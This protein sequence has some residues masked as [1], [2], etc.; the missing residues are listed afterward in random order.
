M[1]HETAI[2]Q[3]TYVRQATFK[4]SK[5][6]GTILSTTLGSCVAAC[7][8]DPVA[9]IGGMNHFLLP[10]DESGKSESSRY[11][12]NLMEQLINEMLKAGASKLNIVA[13]VFGGA[14]VTVGGSTV[15]ARN[16]DFVKSFLSREGIPCLASSLGGDCPR[17]I[18]FWP[19]TGRVSQMQLSVDAIETEMV[20]MSDP[21]TKA[22]AND[23]EIWG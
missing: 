16:G 13:K 21:Q 12:V 20:P 6:P 15:G 19:I 10:S 23:T 18:R 22:F 14:N 11:G 8:H 1:A 7:L 4:V 17:K 2:G 5:E 3:T 9:A